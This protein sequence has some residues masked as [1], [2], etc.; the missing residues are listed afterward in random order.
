MVWKIG[1]PVSWLLSHV[2]RSRGEAEETTRSLLRIV[3]WAAL[4]APVVIVPVYYLLVAL[5]LLPPVRLPPG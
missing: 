2:P 4:L 1:N 5:G 3:F